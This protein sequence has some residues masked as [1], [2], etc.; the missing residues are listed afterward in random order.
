MIL[1][2]FE[3]SPTKLKNMITST[4]TYQFVYCTH[5]AE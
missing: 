3:I 5:I 1:Y 4:F 2:T